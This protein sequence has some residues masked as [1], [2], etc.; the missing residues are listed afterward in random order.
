M[1]DDGE[2]TM[3]DKKEIHT[4]GYMHISDEDFNKTQT[5]I[6][7]SPP[8]SSNEELLKQMN[9]KL[10]ARI[11][12]LEKY[13]KELQINFLTRTTDLEINFRILVDKIGVN[14]LYGSFN[15]KI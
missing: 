4:S 1:V 5:T 13:M 9:E 7:T 12:E 8:F 14:D 10:E 6:I 3:N 15:K 2:E 11:K